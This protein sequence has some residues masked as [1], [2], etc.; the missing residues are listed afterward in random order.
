MQFV[1][2]YVELQKCDVGYL[3]LVHRGDDGADES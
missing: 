1:A 3:E 2:L